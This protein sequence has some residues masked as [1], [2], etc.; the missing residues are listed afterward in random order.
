MKLS[1]SSILASLAFP[2]EAWSSGHDLESRIFWAVSAEAER[3]SGL[4]VKSFSAQFLA[5]LN[6]TVTFSKNKLSRMIA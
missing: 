4:K 5:E 1:V 3:K 2:R 6:L